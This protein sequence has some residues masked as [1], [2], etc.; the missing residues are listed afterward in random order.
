MMPQANMVSSGPAGPYPASLPGFMATSE[1]DALHAAAAHLDD[2]AFGSHTGVLMRESI[3][4]QYDDKCQFDNRAFPHNRARKAAKPPGLVQPNPPG[5]VQPS[6]S[7][8]PLPFQ[9]GKKKAAPRSS[10][11]TPQ[12]NP[13]PVQTG[14][15]V[16]LTGIPAKLMSK[17]MME[18]ILDQAGLDK[19]VLK[20]HFFNQAMAHI[21][22]SS[23]AA[24]DTCVEHFNGCKWSSLSAVSARLISS[25]SDATSTVP[26]EP[27][28][29]KS[30]FG[31]QQKMP[32]NSLFTPFNQLHSFPTDVK[33]SASLPK[34][35]RTNWGTS[36]ASTTVSDEDADQEFW[37]G[38]WNWL[39]PGQTISC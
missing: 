36:D 14:H 27:H 29:T 13:P 19:D 2:L 26:A 37:S 4:R 34:H 20:F 23:R 8:V 17:P 22:L 10:K 15:K 12:Q 16:E 9:K 35:V 3:A 7:S 6:P 39:S 1:G 32:G 33:G 18:A 31:G 25:P 21:W 11:P 28:T 24:A 38:E 30:T 5:L